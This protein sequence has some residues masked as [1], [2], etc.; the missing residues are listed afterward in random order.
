MLSLLAFDADD[1]LWHN[2]TVFRLTEKRFAKALSAYAQP[3]HLMERLLEAE[4]RNLA[5]YGYGIKGFTLS[6]IET[7]LE[8]TDN[9]APAEMIAEILGYAKEMIA[10]PVKTLPRVRETLEELRERYRLIVITKGDLFD[11]ERKLA[12]SGLGELFSGVEIVSEKNCST[13]QRIFAKHAVA[14]Q[15]A[16]M[17]G[18]S[19]KSDI[20]PALE[21]GSWAVYIPHDLTWALERAEEPIGRSR[22][23][24]LTS[25]GDLKTLLRTEF[26]EG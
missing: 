6:M 15:D 16:L 14:P 5:F 26:G 24:K 2:E 13:Y 20:L 3:D 23:R 1:T 9:R 22:F 8:I 4:R 21:A 11:Q 25:L 17:V 12:Q 19:L 18:N 10:H 7:A